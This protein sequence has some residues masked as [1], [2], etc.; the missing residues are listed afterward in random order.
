MAV[1]KI[2]YPVFFNH[3]WQNYENKK[4]K[5]NEEWEAF[6]KDNMQPSKI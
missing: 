2:K 6:F 5:T 1:I 3:D 4:M